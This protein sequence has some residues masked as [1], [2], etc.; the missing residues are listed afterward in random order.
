MTTSGKVIGEHDGV[1]FYTLGQRH[2]IGVGGGTPYFVSA[3]NMKK[4]IL[5]VG[6]GDTD[7]KLF[8]KE[9]TVSGMHWIGGVAPKFPLK[10][11]ARIRYRQPLQECRI[12]N[13]ELRIKKGVR[14][15][16]SIIHN[17]CFLIQ[18]RVPQRAVTPGQSIVFYKGQE[19]LGGGVID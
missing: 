9:L 19:M 12:T 7:T 15:Q 17:S 6:E 5:V 1:W 18:F 8:S 11:K 13:Q 2:G 14:K 10:V 3:K 16:N 4:N